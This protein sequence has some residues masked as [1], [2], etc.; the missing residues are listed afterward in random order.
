M[1]WITNLKR[2]AK[3]CSN[4]TYVFGDD[5]TEKTQ[6]EYYEE[7]YFM[8]EEELT[9][10]QSET[11]EKALKTLRKAIMDEYPDIKIVTYLN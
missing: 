1:R 2:N 11:I 10:K 8:Y 3:E 6:Y 4:G 5:Y 9:I 7:M